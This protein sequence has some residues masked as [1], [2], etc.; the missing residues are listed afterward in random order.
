MTIKIV[1]DSTCDLPQHIV[2]DLDIRVV[3]LYINIGNQGYR[4]GIDISRKEFYENLPNY[5]FHPTTGTPST[6]S[7]QAVY[8]KLLQ[9]GATQVL[10]I[11]ISESLSGTVNVARQAASEYPPQQ[12]I[13]RDGGQLT[14]GTGFQVE[15]AAKMAQEGKSMHDILAALKDLGDRTLVAAGINTLTYLRRS[16]RMNAILTGIGSLL[17]LKPILEMNKGVPHSAKVRTS[18]KAMDYLVKKLRL[19]VPIEKFALLH[20]NAA[21]KAEELKNIVLDILP[22]A[23]ITSVDITPVLGAHLGPGA[24]GY[25]VVSRD[26]IK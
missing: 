21:E 23:N 13:V 5:P 20:T 25:V 8:D 3:P 12:V 9:E 17:K 22:D 24:V 6:K 7:F 18:Q 4:D 10:S 1:T 15:L 14:L 2:D 26:Q 11:H 16:G 19:Q